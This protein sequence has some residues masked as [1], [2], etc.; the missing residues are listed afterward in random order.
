MTARHEPSTPSNIPAA[1]MAGSEQKIIFMNFISG[2]E[3]N[4]KDEANKNEGL[5]EIRSWRSPA[6]VALRTSVTSDGLQL[7]DRIR[8]NAQ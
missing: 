1:P 3:R 4:L 6:H 5:R 8:E 2:K 7:S